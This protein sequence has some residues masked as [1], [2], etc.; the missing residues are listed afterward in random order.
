MTGVDASDLTATKTGTVTSGTITV[1]PSS[2]TVYTVSVAGVAGDG[3]LRLDLSS[4]GTGITDAVGNAISGG[5]TGGGTYTIDNTAPTLF[6]SPPTVTYANSGAFIDYTVTYNDANLGPLPS[7][8]VGA[9]AVFNNLVYTGNASL[10]SL[11]V[12]NSVGNT[13]K[14]EFH[15]MTGD[16]T[17]AFSI[18]AGTASDKAGN[19]ALASPESVAF[20]V[21]N[22][23][24]SITIGAPSVAATKGG[25]VSYTVTY[26]DANFSTS[27]LGTGN[28][29]LNATGTATGTVAV[30]GSGTSYTVTI[31]STG[32]DG[33]LGFTIGAGT[34]TDLAG[35]TAAASSA[36]ATFTVDNTA[37]TVSSI[38]ATTPSNNNPTNA[39]SVGYTVTF[40]E[41]VTGVDNTDFTATVSGVSTTGITVTPVSSSVYTVTVNGVSGNGT[42]RLDLNSSSTG[43]T[44]VAGNAISGGF[45]AGDTYTIDNTPPVVTIGAPSTTITNTGP[46]TYDVSYSDA[47]FNSSSLSSANITVNA[48]PGAAASSVTV[49]Q[50]SP[51]DYTVTLSGITGF[52]ALGISV[53]AGTSSDRAGNTDAGAGPSG[54]FSVDNTAPTVTS[55][56]ATT[57]SNANPTNATSVTYT[58]TFSKPVTG[59]D[60]SD[61]TVSTSGTFGVVTSISGS[62]NTYLVT[63]GSISG[64][65]TLELNMTNSGDPIKDAAGNTLTTSPFGDTYTIDQTLPTAT[66]SAPSVTQTGNSGSGSVTYTVTY[67][68][69]NFNTS[70]LTGSGIT[71]IPTGTAT[72][73]VA[74]SGSGTSYTVTISGITGLGTIG[75]SVGAGFA[76]DLA[77]NTDL[78]AGPSATFTVLSSNATLSLIAL[79]PYSTLTN[80]GTVGSTTTYT[81]TASNATTSVTITPT[82]ADATATVK[83]NGVTVMSGTASIGQPLNVG[84]NTIPVVVTAQDGTTTRTYS[85]T[86]TRAQSPNA[87]LTSIVLSPFSSL[88]NTTG[89]T[90]TTSVGNATSSVTVTPTTRDATATRKK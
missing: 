88:V 53:Q 4:S 69:A 78:G 44:D 18:P 49:T 1:T 65:G 46:V 82:T 73:T 29:T 24:P 71:L 62:G 35:N 19:A 77:G 80:T 51:T 61:F 81:T 52:G 60:E 50:N 56:A 58:V 10:G 34:A 67:A 28:I 33:T 64:N 54:T 21:D 5:F 23:P 76:N 42:V 79:N 39:T 68:D 89:T 31:S 6:I 37:P 40:S 3:S 63:V 14:I 57:P 83:V 59:V 9:L 75:I 11:Q 72:G 2:S 16:G 36:S 20:I 45:T 48:T 70:N 22:T 84:A 74:V 32:G 38:T 12:F 66:I 87:R 41:G 17:V 13:V 26:A 15:G 47:N 7:Q 86:V 85:V 25:P 27:T 90:Y 43:I 30:S 55:I 8:P